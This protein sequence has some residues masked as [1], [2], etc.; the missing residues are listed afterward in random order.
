MISFAVNLLV[1]FQMIEKAVGYLPRCLFLKVKDILHLILFELNF[2][3]LYQ[4]VLKFK[5]LSDNIFFDWPCLKFKMKKSSSSILFQKWFVHIEKSLQSNR[6]SECSFLTFPFVT[7]FLC[8]YPLGTVEELSKQSRMF[9]NS[10]FLVKTVLT[11]AKDW[12]AER[13]NYPDIQLSLHSLYYKQA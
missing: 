13:L 5:I 3:S 6:F 10:S 11:W 2:Y 8:S 7:K 12:R 1:W 9:S 4:T